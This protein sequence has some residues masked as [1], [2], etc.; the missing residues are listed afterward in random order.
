MYQGKTSKNR[1]EIKDIENITYY[2]FLWY[3]SRGVLRQKKRS[4]M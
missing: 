4:M 1:F 3:T 2:T